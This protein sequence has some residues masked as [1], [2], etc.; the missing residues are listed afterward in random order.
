MKVRLPAPKTEF[1]DMGNLKKFTKKEL[2]AKRGPDKLFDGEFGDLTNGQIVQVTIVMP[3]PVVR[4]SAK[5][6]AIS[7]SRSFGIT[8]SL[9]SVTT[10]S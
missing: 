9:F 8:V 2:D 6:G 10:A 7:K 5:R 4:V 3:K 1:D